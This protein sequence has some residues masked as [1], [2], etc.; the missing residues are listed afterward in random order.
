[1]YDILRNLLCDKKTD[2]I[3]K[4]FSLSHIIYL[5][6]I[7]SIIIIAIILLKN[8]SENTKQKVINISI[9]IAFG[10]YIADFFLMPFSYGEID[11]EKL[12]F[13]ICTA[14]CLMCFISC[15]NK[16]LNRFKHQFALIGFISNLVYIIYPAGVM[17]HQVSPLSY[18]VYQTLLFHGSMTAYGLFILFFDNVKLNFKYCYKELIILSCI[19]LWA[20]IG[21]TLYTGIITS[22]TNNYNWFFVVQDPFAII[23]LEIAKFIMPIL[24]VI[25][26]FI[27]VLLIYL[28]YNLIVKLINKKKVILS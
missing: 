17:W 27:A 14:M 26:F 4:C 15:H 13:H 20:V 6:I 2:N 18:R 24:T 16:F 10:L 1:M 12:P 9:N 5:T 23:P 28:I 19:S 7:F 3:F 22:S 8:K 21:N 25:I 11:I